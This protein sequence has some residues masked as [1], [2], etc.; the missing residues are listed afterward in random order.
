LYATSEILEIFS[1][2]AFTLCIGLHILGKEK[3]RGWE[4]W[5]GWVIAVLLF[6]FGIAARIYGSILE[7]RAE[8][9]RKRAQHEITERRLK[10]LEA[11]GVEEDIL[12]VLSLRLDKPALA[13]ED[14]VAWLEGKIGRER[15]QER[16]SEVLRY[17]RALPE[18]VQQQPQDAH[19]QPAELPST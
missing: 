9:Q 7:S 4:E 19:Q 8:A 2:V 16:L 15:A 17:T 1:A 13:V 18:T 6:L 10:T 12:D 11:V 14:F 5:Q 3:L